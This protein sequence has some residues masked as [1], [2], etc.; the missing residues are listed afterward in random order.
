MSSDLADHAELADAFYP[1]TLQGL[2][3]ELWRMNKEIHDLRAQRD[4]V[5]AILL[6]WSAKRHDGAD[7]PFRVGEVIQG[8]IAPPVRAVWRMTDTNP[9]KWEPRLQFERRDQAQGR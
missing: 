5:E 6:A 2:A 3:D 4:A 7:E 8:K 1:G 9:A